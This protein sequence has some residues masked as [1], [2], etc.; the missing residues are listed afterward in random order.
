MDKR[1]EL[2]ARVV[3]G[4]GLRIFEV[5]IT[6]VLQILKRHLLLN[7]VKIKK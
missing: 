6:L 1:M 4:V 3:P 5:V 7:T 2:G